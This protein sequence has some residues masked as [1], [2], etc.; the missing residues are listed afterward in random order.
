[1]RCL[2]SGVNTAIQLDPE[3]RQSTVKRAMSVASVS[4]SLSPGRISLR[5]FFLAAICAVLPTISLQAQSRLLTLAMVRPDDLLSRRE[6]TTTDHVV[7]EAPASI[8]TPAQPEP[9]ASEGF[10]LLT[11]EKFVLSLRTM[12]ELRRESQ[13]SNAFSLSRMSLRD[14]GR[15]NTWACLQAGYGQLFNDKTPLIYGR[16]GSWLEEPSCGYFRICFSF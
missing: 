8:A 13:G 12:Q 1:M 3:L 15:P 4:R 5:L 14:L 6:A 9:T 2:E 16:N 11:A 7:R 10:S